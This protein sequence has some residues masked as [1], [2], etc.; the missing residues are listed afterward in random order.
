MES[1]KRKRLLLI[2]AGVALISVLSFWLLNQNTEPTYEGRPL[3]EW[4]MLHSRTYRSKQTDQGVTIEQAAEAI[5]AI[6]TNGLPYLVRWTGYE[7][8]EWRNKLRIKVANGPYWLRDTPLIVNLISGED[9]N[10][11]YAQEAFYALGALATPAIPGLQEIA[12][13]PGIGI[14]R[15]R[16]LLALG[17]VGSPSVPAL[18]NM[19]VT[20]GFEGTRKMSTLIMAFQI[21]GTNATAAA[22][23]FIQMLQSADPVVAME[24]ARALERLR[25]DADNVVP[26]LIGQIAHP[27]PNVRA[28]VAPALAAYR[29]R[30]KAAIPALINALSDTNP[31][32]R[33]AVAEAIIRIDPS[34]LPEILRT[35]APPQ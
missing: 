33:Q 7:S 21:L 25:L 26:A 17:S 29:T 16:A 9:G 18:T 24:G 2:L 13:R 6:G 10:A 15:D 1:R 28:L 32:V 31:G 3:S 27:D 5:R 22:P 34:V 11:S 23:I 20:A 4:I 14:S 12:C 8:A 35:P 30:A 19:L